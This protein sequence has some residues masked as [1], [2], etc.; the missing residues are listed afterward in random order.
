[1]FYVVIMWFKERR[2][3]TRAPAPTQSAPP[4]ATE[5]AVS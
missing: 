5:P 1:V 2:A 4:V 3:K